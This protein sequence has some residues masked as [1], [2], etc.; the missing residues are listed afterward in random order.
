MTQGVLASFT[1]HAVERKC[2]KR[3]NL[4]SI[5]PLAILHTYCEF[6]KHMDGSML[7]RYPK[8]TLH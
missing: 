2:S 3:I 1:F 4:G 6:M 7:E 5:A 8:G